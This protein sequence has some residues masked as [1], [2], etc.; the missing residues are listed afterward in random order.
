M[1]RMVSFLLASM[2]ALLL[3]SCTKPTAQPEGSYR[4]VGRL[5]VPMSPGVGIT[6]G[7]PFRR[8]FEQRDVKGSINDAGRW[9][10]ENVVDHSHFRCGIYEVGIQLG[11]GVAGC[12]QAEWF[13][14]PEYGTRE[15]HCNSASRI[16]SGGGSLPVTR[17]QVATGNCVRVLVRCSGTCG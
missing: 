10:I 1:K 3:Q 7:Q 13:S 2:A 8:D 16:H 5:E 15:R 17:K 4:V 11:R 14:A 6:E 12:S 9:T